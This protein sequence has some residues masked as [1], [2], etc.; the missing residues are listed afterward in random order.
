MG[1]RVVVDRDTMITQD[2]GVDGRARVCTALAEVGYYYGLVEPPPCKPPIRLLGFFSF[3][4]PRC[5]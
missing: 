4:G 3:G 1:G 2:G 5:A